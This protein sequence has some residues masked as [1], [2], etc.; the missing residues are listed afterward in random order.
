MFFA[1]NIG[2]TKQHKFDVIFFNEFKHI[3]NR[4]GHTRKSSKTWVN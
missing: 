2:K 3:V 4:V 1:L